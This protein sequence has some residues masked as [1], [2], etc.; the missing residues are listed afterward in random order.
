VHLEEVLGMFFDFQW[1]IIMRELMPWAGP[2]FL[3]I[4]EL[5][6]TNV[7]LAIILIGYWAVK[8]RETIVFALLI[9]FSGMLN[10][11]LKGA[12][13][14]PRPPE[15]DWIKGATAAG[16]S[17]PS[18]HA[19]SSTVFYGW[20][21]IKIRTWWMAILSIALIVLIGLSRVYMGVHWM[22]DVLLGWIIGAV[23]I[24]FVWRFQGPIETYLSTYSRDLLYLLLVVFGIV[25][26]ILT[27]LF[28]Q[29]PD[30]NFGANGGL[31][32]GLAIGLWL[33]GRYVNFTTK[34]DNNLRLAL[35]VII[36]VVLVF[37]LMN[38]LSLIFPSD[39]YWRM[40]RYAIVAIVG[41]FIWP[42]IFERIHL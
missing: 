16:Y 32:V 31:L 24:L 15:T 21:G 3:L 11:W 17:L 7:Y 39:V 26:T 9:L 2:F 40:I 36:G 22:G 23:L 5:G 13:M 25:A 18:G 12:F 29:V 34:S 37:L 38:G 20:L 42:L 1:T 4:T 6:G 27:E 28:I 8:K 30:D 33:E 10:Y 19:Q 35:R 14:N 41:A